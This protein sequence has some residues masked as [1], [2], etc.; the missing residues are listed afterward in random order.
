[1]PYQMMFLIR[2]IKMSERIEGEP[3]RCEE[4]IDLER[5]IEM[6][7]EE[8]YTRATATV[9]YNSGRTEEF[10]CDLRADKTPTKK[11]EKKVAALRAYPKVKKIE[12]VRY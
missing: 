6:K 1:M 4:T 11:F 8:A 3:Y 10:S 5:L 9:V 2:I 12:V 7:D